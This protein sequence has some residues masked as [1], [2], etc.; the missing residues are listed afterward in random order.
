MNLASIAQQMAEAAEQRIIFDPERCLYSG[1][2]FSTCDGCFE[3]CPAMA[4]QPGSPPAF[5]EEFCQTCRACLPVCPVGAYSYSGIDAV[6]AIITSIT[7]Q[8]LANCDLFCELNPVMELGPTGSQAGLRIRGCLAAIGLG[9]QLAILA[10]GIGTVQ[11]RLDACAGCPWNML[12]NQIELLVGQ[13]RSLL[14]LEDRERILLFRGELA[15]SNGVERPFWNVESP[16]RTRREFIQAPDS[17]GSEDGGE[18]SWFS[19]RLLMIEAVR[20]GDLLG[21]DDNGSPSL[22]GMNFAT[23]QISDAC[24]A[25]G[26]CGRACP[27]KALEFTVSRSAFELLFMS[28][29]CIGCEICMHVCAPQAIEIDHRPTF[30]QVFSEERFVL[31]QDGELVRCRKCSAQF[32]ASLGSSYCPVCDFR[33]KNPF[34]S[35]LP[36]GLKKYQSA[37]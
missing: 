37:K 6:Q 11:L 31:L 5:D 15:G 19:E 23:I 20:E 36:P 29:A 22:A 12:Q 3:I 32:A 18:N 27:T 33:R 26:T 7:K 25:C 35:I 8:G 28:E 13:A 16:P 34:G 10:Q 9:G 14:A 17:E 24:S 21:R 30:D 4:I 2:K 1:D